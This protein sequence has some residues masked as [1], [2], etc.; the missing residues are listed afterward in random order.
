MR[1]LKIL[2]EYIIL[3]RKGFNKEDRMLRYAIKGL[4][5]F[6]EFNKYYDNKVMKGGK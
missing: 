4:I 2:K 3:K 6:D 5:T 1:K